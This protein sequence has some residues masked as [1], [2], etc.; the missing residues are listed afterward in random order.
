MTVT[1]VQI[2]EDERIVALDLKLALEALGC[3]VTGIVADGEAALALARRLPP[4][5][6]LMDIHL[7]G[8]MDGTE[9]AR[10]IREEQGVPVVFLTAFAEDDTLRKASA[11][12][13]YGYLVKPYELR[14]LRAT[15]QMA[16]SRR[17]AER[18][19]ERA[20]ER[21]RLAVDAAELGVW[22]WD[23]R[24]GQMEVTGHFR[25]IMGLAPQT[26]LLGEQDFLG[27]VHDEDRGQLQAALQHPEVGFAVVRMLRDQGAPAWA[28]VYA[29]RHGPHR[30]VGVLRDVTERREMEEKLRQ[31]S[32]VFRT[33][34]EGIV[35]MDREQRIISVNPAFSVLTGLG[36]AEVL[37]RQVDDVLHVRR[38]SP[39]FYQRLETT[40][41]GYWN[42]EVP[43]RRR[44]GESF[45]AWEHVCA[46]RDDEGS[47]AQYVLAFSDLSAIRDAELQLNHLAFHDALTGLGNR[48]LLGECMEGEIERSRRSGIPILLIFMDLDGFK[49][50]NDTPGHAVGDNLLKQIA[51]RLR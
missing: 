2:V 29:K 23:T 44:S 24:D 19:I 28:E 10:R 4:D 17:Q 16:L 33:T 34:A 47:V 49:T 14:E 40:P 8:E 22:E 42:G 30:V 35:I 9:V 41:L 46:V 27:R 31:A 15:L 38:H 6:I 11:S 13:P 26:F 51:Q 3:E 39:Q 12:A 32:V 7:E 1:R 21:L 20:E 36:A 43:C 50:I 45:V 25:K 5:L 37:G 48:H 18:Q